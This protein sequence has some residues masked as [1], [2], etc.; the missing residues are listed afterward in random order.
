MRVFDMRDLVH[1]WFENNGRVGRDA[2]EAIKGAS[3]SYQMRP[4]G[5]EH[6][7]DCLVGLLGL[8]MRF[9]VG[10]TFVEQPDV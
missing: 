6:L 2:V 1:H 4:F 5:F 8:L 10:D 3:V 9:G 7:P